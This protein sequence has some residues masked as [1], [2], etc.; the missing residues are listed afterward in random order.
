MLKSM[1]KILPVD[2]PWVFLSKRTET[3]ELEQVP[4]GH[5]EIVTLGDCERKTHGEEAEYSER[6][7]RGEE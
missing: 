3:G 7:G 2:N 5:R 1:F 4:D 6:K